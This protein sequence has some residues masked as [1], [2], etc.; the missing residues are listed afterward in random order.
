MKTLPAHRSEQTGN[1][2]LDRIQENVRDLIAFVRSLASRLANTH[3]T[4]EFSNIVLR[5]SRAITATEFAGHA[6]IFEGKLTADARLS[7]PSATRNASWTRLVYNNTVGG[8]NV[9]L[10]TPEGALN[11]PASTGYLVITTDRFGPETWL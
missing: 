5:G 1:S 2:G 3:G 8:F 7:V 11:V 4:G 10:T 9:T 6:W